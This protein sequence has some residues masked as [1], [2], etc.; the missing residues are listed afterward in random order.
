MEELIKEYREFKGSVATTVDTKPERAAPGREY[1]K[2]NFEDKRKFH[3]PRINHQIKVPECRLLGEDGHQYGVV[4]MME[5][6]RIAEDL[7]LDLIEVSPN[8]QPPVVK[9]IDYGKFKYEQQ[10]KA[11]EAKKKQVVVQLKEIQFRPNIEQH[12][13]DTKVK[14]A[15]GFLA[16]A[17]KVKLVMQFKGREMAYKDA[18][19]AKFLEI[20]KTLEEFG[21]V[22]ESP[23]KFM[24][25]RVICIIAPTKKIPVKRSDSKPKKKEEKLEEKKE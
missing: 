9:V 19:F 23:P 5:A 11:S 7:G 18:G 14:K 2:G 25:N 10:K 4:P 22:V 13:L 24:G 8:A 6:R 15:E 3:G 1:G 17:D 21:S 16:D 20:I 12:D